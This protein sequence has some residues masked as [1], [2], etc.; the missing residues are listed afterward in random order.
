MF[1]SCE[2]VKIVTRSRRQWAVRQYNKH[3]NG[4]EQ[5]HYVH[6]K[7]YCTGHGV[8][9]LIISHNRIETASVRIAGREL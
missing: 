3:R 2:E 8:K 9:E 5:Y 4:R 6:L 1:I 7:L